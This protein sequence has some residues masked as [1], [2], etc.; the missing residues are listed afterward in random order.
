MSREIFIG[1]PDGPLRC[2]PEGVPLPI[3][4]VNLWGSIS[5]DWPEIVVDF[6]NGT[7]RIFTGET[8]PGMPYSLVHPLVERARSG[9]TNSMSR[10]C[11]Y[12]DAAAVDNPLLER[13]TT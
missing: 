5:L 12:I 1:I 9:D 4:R 11:T 3:Q 7:R 6:F 10:L 13:G 8:L 2:D